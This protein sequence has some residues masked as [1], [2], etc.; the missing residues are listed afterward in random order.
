MAETKKQIP[1]LP[2]EGALQDSDLF[3]AR[4]IGDVKVLLGSIKAYILG[5]IARLKL[6]DGDG[7]DLS[8]ESL[9]GNS[10]INFENSGSSDKMTL[11]SAGTDLI[12]LE[13]DAGGQRIKVNSEVIGRSDQF[14][15]SGGAGFTFDTAATQGFGYDSGDDDF[16]IGSFTGARRMIL[17]VVDNLNSTSINTPLSANMGRIL[18]LSLDA[19]VNVI[20]VQ[21]NLTSTSV[22]NPLSANQGKVINDKVSNIDGSTLLTDT[23]D[24]SSLPSGLYTY[25]TNTLNHPVDGSGVSPNEGVIQWYWN[26]GGLAHAYKTDFGGPVATTKR[27]RTFADDGQG[28]G[29]WSDL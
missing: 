5:A 16:F 15:A 18:D 3:V 19:K 27:R 22:S 10:G 2:S 25:D 11:V 12:E 23:D 24:L 28:W 1:E 8:L 7:S 17:E 13:T 21:D 4:Q 14:D 26:N 20:D 6:A 9:D 29:N